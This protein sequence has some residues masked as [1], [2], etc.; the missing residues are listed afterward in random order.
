MS[1][2]RPQGWSI[3]WILHGDAHICKTNFRREKLTSTCRIIKNK[4]IV[5][6]SFWDR[7][8]TKYL[9]PLNVNEGQCSGPGDTLDGGLSVDRMVHLHTICKFGAP[10]IL[11][12]LICF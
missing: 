3:Y 6:A 9:R 7:G 8:A 4:Q 5:A 1:A 12:K 10:W 2:L 11:R